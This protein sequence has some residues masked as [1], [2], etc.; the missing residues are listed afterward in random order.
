[1]KIT[2]VEPKRRKKKILSTS[3]EIKKAD[4]AVAKA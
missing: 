2:I 3:K 4:K 1:M